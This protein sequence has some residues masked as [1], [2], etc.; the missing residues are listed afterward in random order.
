MN[1]CFVYKGVLVLFD[2]KIGYFLYDN[3]E[4]LV[5]DSR[6]R[7]KAFISLRIR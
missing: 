6:D 4:R 3:G 1:D 7:C 2:D 5:F